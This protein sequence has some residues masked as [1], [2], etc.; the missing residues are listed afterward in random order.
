MY[1][2]IYQ[3]IN[4]KYRMFTTADYNTYIVVNNLGE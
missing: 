1:K 2:L 4:S 3:T